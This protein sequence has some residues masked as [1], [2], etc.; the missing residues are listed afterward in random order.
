MFVLLYSGFSMLMYV[1]DIGWSVWVPDDTGCSQEPMT[2]GDY[3]NGLERIR[4]G[5]TTH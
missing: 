1:F 5:S 2:K 4:F 3:N